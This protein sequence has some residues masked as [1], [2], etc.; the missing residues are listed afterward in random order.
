[1]PH[2]ASTAITICSCYTQW[3]DWCV[4]IRIIRRTCSSFHS[5][6]CVGFS[7][8]LYLTSPCASAFIWIYRWNSITTIMNIT[9]TYQQHNDEQSDP[10]AQSWLDERGVRG[11]ERFFSLSYVIT[12]LCLV[13][14]V[15]RRRSWRCEWLGRAAILIFYV[16]KR[17]GYASNVTQRLHPSNEL[18]KK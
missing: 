9:T 1:M 14:C 5:A 6:I 2:A 10:S 13:I 11:S 3:F 18:W 15:W 17:L 12:V 7:Q 8:Q 16:R 4:Q